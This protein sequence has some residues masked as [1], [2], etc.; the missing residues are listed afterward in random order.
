MMRSGRVIKAH[1]RTYN[2][3]IQV[4]KGDVVRV[5]KRELWNDKY[6]WVWCI[7]T[8]GK[9]GWAPESFVEIQGEQGIALRDYN[10]I[11]LSVNIGDDLTILEEASGWYWAKN[12][13]ESYGWVPVEC[14]AID[15]M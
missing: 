3:P 6:P 8:S 7:A 11:E 2:D 4:K 9:E 5:T 14:V 10:A 12:K 13:R 15:L 1:Q